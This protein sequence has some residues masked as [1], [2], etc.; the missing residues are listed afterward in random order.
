MTSLG[1]QPVAQ[2]ESKQ[3]E[4]PRSFLESLVHLKNGQLL[5]VM[6]P[7]VTRFGLLGDGSEIVVETIAFYIH[8][9]KIPKTLQALSKRPFIDLVYLN[10]TPKANKKIILIRS[11]D[12]WLLDDCGCE[13]GP[14]G[15]GGKE[16]R[17]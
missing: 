9:I 10:H 6:I 7:E 3:W 14:F 15:L 8:P 16:L 5:Q 17:P 11:L 13:R 12:A 4:G 2:M 1:L